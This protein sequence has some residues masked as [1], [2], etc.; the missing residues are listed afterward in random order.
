[1]KNSQNQI[2][3]RCLIG[4]GTIMFVCTLFTSS[5]LIIFQILGVVFLM[6]GA[7]RSSLF[8]SEVLKNKKDNEEKEL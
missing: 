5:G 3:N 1:M 7:Y 2:F 4:L 6:V 8:Q